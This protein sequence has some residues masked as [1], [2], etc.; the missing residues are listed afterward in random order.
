M[1]NYRIRIRSALGVLT[2]AYGSFSYMNSKAANRV[3]F[4]V[5]VTAT[6]RKS[7]HI[8]LLILLFFA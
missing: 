8:K 7:N 6:S 1:V 2:C 3:G 4:A 5:F